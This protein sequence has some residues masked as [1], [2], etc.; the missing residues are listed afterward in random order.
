M[1]QE[2]A[3]LEEV[4]LEEE[5]SESFDF[6][7]LEAKLQQQLE[8]EFSDLSFL[9]DE[10]GEINNPDALGD[11]IQGVV[12]EQFINQ[13]AAVAGEDFIEEN[14]GLTLD[15]SKDAHIQTTENF[16]EGKIATHNSEIDYQQRHDDWQSNFQK[17]KGPDGKETVVTHETRTGQREAT[18]VKG[19]RTPFDKD[20][21]RGSA[22]KHTDMDHTVSAAEII[23]DPA[24]NAHMTKDEQIGFAN[25]E[26]NLNEMDS[27]LNRSKGDKS[28]SD[29]LD[30]PNSKGQKPDEIFDISPEE[31]AKLRQKDAEAREEF[32]RLKKE[33]E[34]RSIESGKRT[35]R[36]EAKRIGGKTVRAVIMTLLAAL[37]KEII[38]KLVKW[39]KSANKALKTLLAS[40][41]EA[42]VSF[43][44][45][46]KTHLMN[47]ADSALTTIFGAIWGPVFNT[48]K[49]VWMM[50]KQGYAAVKQAIHYLRSP[51]NKGKPKGILYMEVGKI[52]MVGYSAA[53]A[54]V[55][56][57]L[58]EKGL[59]AI[60]VAGAFFSF[61]IPLLGTL[62]NLLGIFFGAVVAGI[63]GALV[64]NLIQKQICELQ[65]AENRVAQIDKNNEILRTQ[66]DIQ[67]VNEQG[68]VVTKAK[69]KQRIS[70]RHSEAAQSMEDSI[71]R[72]AENCE[73]DGSINE[74]FDEID[75][76]FSELE[77]DE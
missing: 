21:P 3:L 19:A 49:K 58:I 4:S 42:I 6:D 64:I 69:T 7:E 33:A 28:M 16:A 15:L 9:Q 76:L 71:N 35:R 1:A 61:E 27:S 38:A 36:A 68:L 40:L 66:H 48:I 18:L 51:E 14:R 63:I 54:I 31:E 74:T 75:K 25:S 26:A 65:R 50:M 23:R 32:E 46:L 72:I 2:N 41:K 70:K 12:W 34:E 73:D 44:H 53:G 30:N 60:P 22:E 45:K 67:V 29:W 52:L 37:I 47:A 59:M 24:A 43:V 13:V 39:L 20:R 11:V 10:S 62:G 57:E 56:S 5:L 17:E 55:L 8:D 77:D